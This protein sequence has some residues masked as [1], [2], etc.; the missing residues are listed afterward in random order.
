[1]QVQDRALDGALVPGNHD[2]AGRVV[3]R[4]GQAELG[5]EL[6]GA[7]MLIATSSSMSV[8]PLV[9]R[10]SISNVLPRC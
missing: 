1:M 10:V 2:L 6:V 3:V 4:D 9:Y 8:K 7:M 5:G